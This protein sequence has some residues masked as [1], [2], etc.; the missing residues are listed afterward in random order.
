MSYEKVAMGKDQVIIGT[1]QTVKAMKNGNAQEVILARDA[2]EHVTAKVLHVANEYEIPYSYVN[3]MKRL[4]KT[5]G[6]EVGAA[7]V[8]IKR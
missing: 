2:D 4:G 5:C 3:S 6:I 7:A 8:A 1:K